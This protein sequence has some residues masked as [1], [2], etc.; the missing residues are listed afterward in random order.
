LQERKLV[1]REAEGGFGIA[2]GSPGVNAC[3]EWNPKN[4]YAVI[5]LSNYDPPSAENVARQIGLW[6]PR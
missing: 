4:T 1:S 6:L 3:V 5:V 2:G